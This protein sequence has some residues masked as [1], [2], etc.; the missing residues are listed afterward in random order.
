MRNVPFLWFYLRRIEAGPL[1]RLSGASSAESSTVFNSSSQRSTDLSMEPSLSQSY[2]FTSKNTVS[3][4]SWP[5]S[6]ATDAPT[7][8]LCSDND[9][10]R[11]ETSPDDQPPSTPPATAGPSRAIFRFKG[12]GIPVESQGS[13]RIS[14]VVMDNTKHII[15]DESPPDKR[16]NAKQNIFDK[17]PPTSPFPEK[18][19]RRPRPPSRKAQHALP[20]HSTANVSDDED[21]LSLSFS[22]PESVSLVSKP[23]RVRRPQSKS[24]KSIGSSDWEKLPPP[25]PPP[26][27]STSAPSSKR[28][29]RARSQSSRRSSSQS[30]R[31]NVRVT[32]DE[33][34]RNA[35]ED[36]EY[37][38]DYDEQGLEEGVLASVGT[39]RNSTGFLAGGGGAGV[40]V[41]MGVGYVA[42]TTESEV[43]GRHTKEEHSRRSVNKRN[44][45]DSSSRGRK[46]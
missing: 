10:E 5:S 15:S 44:D 18:S 42:G 16:L 3:G 12:N 14:D 7:P 40:P 36:H 13:Q 25:P 19:P 39:R 41:F 1:R 11:D 45:S 35:F 31:P 9:G 23:Q 22:S 43:E 30:S 27:P 24:R 21:P 26:P 28:A 17:R 37:N 38:L 34:L 2:P 29:S 46:R 6:S 32:L 20:Y 33:E 4:R 8:S